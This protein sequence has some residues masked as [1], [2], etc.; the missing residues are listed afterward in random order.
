MKKLVVLVAVVAVG[1]VVYNYATTGT[2]ALVPP[3][4]SMSPDER[5]VADLEQRFEDARH[6]FAQA[7]RGAGLTGM[8]TTGDAEAAMRSVQQISSDLRELQKRLSS[9]PAKQKA[10]TLAASIESY[11]RDL[12]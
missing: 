3:S 10:E 1:L 6:E 12:R 4:L 5:A 7:G 11:Q 8:D 2:V 9:A